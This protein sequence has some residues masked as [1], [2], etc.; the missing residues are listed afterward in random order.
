[1]TAFQKGERVSEF[2]AVDLTGKRYHIVKTNADGKIVLSTAGTDLHLGVLDSEPKLKQ[3]ADVVMANGIGTFKVKAGANIAKDAKITSN[4][5]GQAVTATTGD[6]AIG[7]A[8]RAAVSGEI[9]EY[10]KLNEKV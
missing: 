5:N 4:A 6:R 10:V 2:G 9:F 7:Y 3:V 1:M 8:Y